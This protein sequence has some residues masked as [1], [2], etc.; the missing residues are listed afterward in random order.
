MEVFLK[1]ILA[2]FSS[3]G[4]AL[5]VLK[6]ELTHQ[7][8]CAL[9]SFAAGALFAAASVAILPESA[10]IL[11]YL[12]TILAFFSGYILFFAIGKYYFHVCP[13]C[14]ASH[15]DEN[16]TKKFKEIAF[17][18]ISALSLHSFM[19]GVAISAEEHHS[20]IFLAIFFHK[21]P[22]GLALASLMLGANY[23]KLKTAFFV[24]AVQL[25]TVIGALS[26]AFIFD[27]FKISERFLYF[28]LAHIGGGF[29]YLSVHAILGEMLKHNLKKVLLFFFI[30]FLIVSVSSLFHSH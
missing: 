5:L 9:I 6:M 30:G 13:A 4:G 2:L 23:S 25:T 3:F 27:S 18:M 14:A 28:I 8:L 1:S 17:L 26:G 20:S 29:I 7:R 16:M 12:E 24:F 22:E 10:H 21:F 19:D 15:F 11:N